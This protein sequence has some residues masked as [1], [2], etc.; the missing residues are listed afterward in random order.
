[1]GKRFSSTFDSDASVEELYAVLTG[2]EWAATKAAHL[3]D[4]S[5]V[6]RRDVAA[7][8]AV[9]LVVSRRLPDGV[10][11]FLQ[12]FLPSDRRVTTSDTWGPAEGG[13][14]R[15][16]WKAEIAGAPARMGGTM[17]IEPLPTGSRYTIDG[18]VKVPVPIVGGKAESFIAEQVVRLAEAE[19]AVV[20]KVLATG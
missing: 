16:T 9:T 6:V 11:G 10:P 19:A 15:A 3:N 20:E 8:E 5:T 13:E 4:D 18:E 7:G 2:P 17:R 12:R 14:R 1:V